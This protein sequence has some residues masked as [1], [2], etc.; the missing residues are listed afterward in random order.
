MGKVYHLASRFKRKYS[1][2]IA[3]RIRRHSEVIEKILD[4]D[5][6][7]LYVFCGQKN[8]TN[9]S[10]FQSAVVAITNKRIIVGQKRVVFGYFLTSITSDLFNDLKIHAGLFFGMIII[11][12]AKEIVYISNLDKASLDEI[13]TN[14]NRIMYE[15]KRRDYQKNEEVK[16]EDK[17]K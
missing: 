8:D 16:D 2:T 17:E 3:S 1:F 7:V 12:T 4:T 9:T 11:D 14:V 13:E 6:K 15:N 10:L 5:E